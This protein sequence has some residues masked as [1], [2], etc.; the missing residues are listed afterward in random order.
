MK[1]ELDKKETNIVQ[2]KENNQE[3]KQNPAMSSPFS[4]SSEIIGYSDSVKEEIEDIKADLADAIRRN[5]AREIFDYF[6]I[7]VFIRKDGTYGI[8]EYRQPEKYITFS[9]IGVDEDKLMENVAKIS[10]NADFRKSNL[11][12]FNK[13]KQIGGCANFCR[14][15]FTLN[16]KLPEV[17]GKIIFYEHQTLFQG[18]MIKLISLI[19]RFI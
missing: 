12:S 5:N 3:L 18:I 15:N 2:I 1:N 11:T 10:G 8:S 13:L 17:K 6:D 16:M 9:D 4:G 14:S 19:K 7:G